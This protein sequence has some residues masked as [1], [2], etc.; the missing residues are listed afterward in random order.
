MAIKNFFDRSWFF[1]QWVLQEVVLART[2]IA[3]IGPF[4]IN[5]RW[6]GVAA[7]ILRTNH[8]H[9]C[10]TL[11]LGGVYNAYLMYR[12]SRQSDLAPSKL[13]I[14]RLLRLTRQFEV[15]DERD[16]VFGLLGIATSDNDPEHGKLF[17]KPNYKI[18]KEELWVHVAVK[19][20]A[21][22][23]DL[24]LLSC[25]QYRGGKLEHDRRQSSF[26]PSN[27]VIVDA[28]DDKNTDTSSRRTRAQNLPS[29]VPQWEYV[30]RTTISAWDF[31]ECFSAARGLPRNMHITHKTGSLVLQ[32]VKA[33][34]IAYVSDLMSDKPDLR[35]LTSSFLRGYFETDL[36]Q[37]L[38]AVTLTAGM[39]PYGSQA[40][41]NRS[42][43]ADFIAYLQRDSRYSH[44]PKRPRRRELT[45]VSGTTSGDASRFSEMAQRVCQ[46]RRL[47][48]TTNG[49]LGL[50]PDI[51]RAG[52]V[53]CVLG[54][55]DTPF[56]LRLFPEH[57]ADA[58]SRRRSRSSRRSSASVQKG[59]ESGTNRYRLVG[60]C[61][62]EGLMKGEAIDAMASGIAL[63]GPIPP[64]LIH[65]QMLQ[66]LAD[67]WR[68]TEEIM[69]EA[70]KA[71]KKDS[72]AQQLERTW[73]DI[74]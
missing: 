67:D 27:D 23:E 44:D 61:F 58:F 47:F 9:E 45:E 53:V 54:G 7:A 64:D 63:Q 12:M 38:Y 74:R 62:V 17:I 19:I 25:V 66:D 3:R 68:S 10:Q 52:D 37:C 22:S 65:E 31:Q 16:R 35:L 1:R 51:L 48:L 43:Q 2:A 32:G 36:G 24:A 8:H 46:S 60:E 56:L 33:G 6:V 55:G 18:S 50:G 49:Y 21:T 20:L 70:Q 4:E 14:L 30:F 26:L 41:N 69:L 29:W 40:K 13:D 57:Q 5:W 42:V 71:L 15:T 72:V 34:E 73:F 39:N 11:K 59:H 28:D